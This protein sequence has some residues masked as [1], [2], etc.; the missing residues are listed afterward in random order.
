MVGPRR[1]RLQVRCLAPR[2]RVAGSVAFSAPATTPL[3]L[4]DADSPKAWAE[5]LWVVLDRFPDRREWADIHIDIIRYAMFAESARFLDDDGCMD[6]ELMFWA[7][8]E[9][10][11]LDPV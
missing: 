7:I 5:M 11:S 4:I 10:E 1:R 9:A 6:V 2:A 3:P 8:Q